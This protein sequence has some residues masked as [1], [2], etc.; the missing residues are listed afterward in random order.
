MKRLLAVLSVGIMRLGSLS[1]CDAPISKLT[2]ATIARNLERHTG[3]PL[4]V[5]D[6]FT[7]DVPKIYCAFKLSAPANTKISARWALAKG[8]GLTP[9]KLVSVGS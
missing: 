5:S 8:D 1:G 2:D 3:K 4:E 6:T 7:M 9:K